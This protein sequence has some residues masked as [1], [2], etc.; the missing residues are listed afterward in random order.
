MLYDLLVKKLK[1][2]EEMQISA[3]H[4][5]LSNQVKLQ[6]LLT[7]FPLESCKVTAASSGKR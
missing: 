3:G 1:Q 6:K 5:S 7:K 2:L 4:K